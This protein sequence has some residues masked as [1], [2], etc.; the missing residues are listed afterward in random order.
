MHR[1]L[2]QENYDQDE[3]TVYRASALLVPFTLQAAL[4]AHLDLREGVA[5]LDYLNLT[6]RRLTL[7]DQKH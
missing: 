5:V 3:R 4:S 6:G 1:Q 7:H 2:V